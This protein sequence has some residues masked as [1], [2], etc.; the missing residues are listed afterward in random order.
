MA[1]SH[2]HGLEK[3]IFSQAY[4]CKECGNRACLTY[5]RTGIFDKYVSCPR[6]GNPAPDRRSRRDKV[7]AMLHTPLRMLHK[8]FGGKIYHC[9]FCRLQFYDVR[10]VRSKRSTAHPEGANKAKLAS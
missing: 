6:C 2:R 10:E 8:L 3:T 4:R 5:L 7:D 1:R 9:V